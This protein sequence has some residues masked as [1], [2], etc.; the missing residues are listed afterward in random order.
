MSVLDQL[1]FKNGSDKK[2]FEV[3][4]FK[5]MLI[6]HFIIFRDLFKEKIRHLVKCIYGAEEDRMDDTSPGPFSVKTWAQF[7]LKPGSWA[8]AIIPRL[9]ASLWACRV[10]IFGL[11]SGA[12]MSFRHDGEFDEADII[13]VYNEDLQDGHYSSALR[14]A[15]QDPDHPEAEREFKTLKCEKLKVTRLFEKEIDEVE[16]KERKKNQ[17]HLPVPVSGMYYSILF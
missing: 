16:R 17:P 10:T 13:L 4:Y 11:K 7:T 5:R 1:H 15:A 3:I 14:I 6:A 2:R 12:S 9:L 8:D